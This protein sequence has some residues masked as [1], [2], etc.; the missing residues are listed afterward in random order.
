MSKTRNRQ[1]GNAGRKIHHK[2]S[3]GNPRMK[4]EGYPKIK[5]VWLAWRVTSPDWKRSESDGG[6]FFLSV[7]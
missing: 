4:G 6:Q 5:A 2:S 3:K 1:T 7:L